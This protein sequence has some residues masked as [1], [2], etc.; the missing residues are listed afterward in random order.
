[1]L[2]RPRVL[3]GF[4]TLLWVDVLYRVEEGQSSALFW[5]PPLMLV[6][7][8]VHGGF[9][10]GLVL[11]AFLG[12]ASVWDYMTARVRRMVKRFSIWLLPLLYAWQ[13]RCLPLTATN[14]MCTC[15]NI[16]LIVS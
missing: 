11:L 10:L 12:C 2:A 13:L 5:L 6:W 16:F 15:I 14:C 3:T 7:V 8:N 9:I 1:M 4:F